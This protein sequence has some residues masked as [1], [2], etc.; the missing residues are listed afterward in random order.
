MEESMNRK[1]IHTHTAREFSRHLLRTAG[2]LVIALSALAG[3]ACSESTAAVPRNGIFYGQSVAVGN[4]TART[5]VELDKGEPVEV[6]VALSES[7][8]AGLP[9][10]HTPGGVVLPDGHHWFEYVLELPASNPTPFKHFVLNWN[11]H[12]HEPHGIYDTPHF[13]FHFYTITDA[14][15]RAITEADPRYAERAARIPA[16]DFLPSGYVSTEQAVETMGVHWVDAA[17]PELNGQ[18]FT[19][20]MIFG[21]WDGQVTFIEPMITRDFLLS[22]TEFSATI[23]IPQKH[24]EP[25][26]YPSGYSIRWNEQAK[27]HRIALTELAKRS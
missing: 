13:D 20:T 22:K 6:G 9:D 5:Y 24:A 27:E 8:L 12:G 17:S 15:R 16:P 2:T 21:T 1:A 19:S 7:A 23:P 11:H 25:G 10:H 18:P 14:E 26:Y 3:G 4:G